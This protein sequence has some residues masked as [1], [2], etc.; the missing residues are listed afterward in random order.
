MSDLTM[1][2]KDNNGV[3]PSDRIREVIDGRKDIKLH[4]S[5]DM[6]IW[7]NEYNDQAPEYDYFTTGEIGNVEDFIAKRIDALTEYLKSIQKK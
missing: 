6:P 7:G 3:F 4:G 5:R 1:L 2:Q